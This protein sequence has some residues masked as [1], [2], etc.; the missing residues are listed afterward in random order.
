MCSRWG[1]A[2]I[3]VVKSGLVSESHSKTSLECDW[4]EDR[5]RKPTTATLA[6][7]EKTEFHT[8][9]YECIYE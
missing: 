7:S 6:V 3:E 4:T 2:R 9:A 8:H 5:K 1:T